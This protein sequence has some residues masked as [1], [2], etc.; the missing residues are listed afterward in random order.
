MAASDNTRSQVSQKLTDLQTSGGQRSN[1]AVTRL[2]SLPPKE[3]YKEMVTAVALW[4][5][6]GDN[7]HSQPSGEKHLNTIAAAAII[8]AQKR[9]IVPDSNGNYPKNE[10]ESFVASPDDF[11]K[12]LTSHYLADSK[13]QA[14]D[15]KKDEAVATAREEID[16]FIIAAYGGE[17]HE[18]EAQPAIEPARQACPYVS[19]EACLSM[20]EEEFANVDMD[21]ADRAAAEAA[22]QAQSDKD[23]K[24]NA[25]RIEKEMGDPDWG[26]KKDDDDFKIEQGDIIEYLMKE[27]ILA[28]AAWVGNKAAGFGGILLYEGGSAAI[29]EA[30]P[31]VRNRKNEITNWFH[32]LMNG[33]PSYNSLNKQCDK[34]IKELKKGLETG[35]EKADHIALMLANHMVVITPQGIVDNQGV[36]KTFEELGL[37]ENEEGTPQQRFEN[38]QKT[39]DSQ[40]LTLMCLQ[41]NATTSEQQQAVQNWLEQQKR[42]MEECISRR[43]TYDINDV[44]EPKVFL[45]AYNKARDEISSNIIFAKR[46]AA[47][48]LQTQLFSEAYIKYRLAEEHKRDPN[49]EIFSDR[50]KCKAFIDQEKLNAERIFLT[51]EQERRRGNTSINGVPILSREGMIEEAEKL[52][53]KVPTENVQDTK[54]RPITHGK[55]PATQNE[56]A[57]LMDEATKP[58]PIELHAAEMKDIALREQEI[59]TTIQDTDRRRGLLEQTRKRANAANE[60]ITPIRNDPVR[61]VNPSGRTN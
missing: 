58:D 54:L 36:L 15:D 5:R 19:P 60:G 21:P 16:S 7:L 17:G 40:L 14:A 18:T 39:S 42:K 34:N 9:G 4:K 8:I 55:P 3:Q 23:E 24:S 57:S 27:V 56:V 53:E 33:N 51:A 28:S 50:K 59:R 30:R 38:L 12:T 25:A 47:F 2:Q 6:H 22:R 29:K 46:L 52:A 37:K 48:K 1:P 43:R 45:K 20:S 26:H 32:N 35:V 11:L 61:R 13:Q 31:W 44:P 10:L 41:L 49:N